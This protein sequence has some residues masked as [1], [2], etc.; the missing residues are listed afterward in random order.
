MNLFKKIFAAPAALPFFIALSFGA[1]ASNEAEL[2]D[3]LNSNSAGTVTI[4]S[5]ILISSS[6]P[7]S[8]DKHFEILLNS[9]SQTYISGASL[10]E[11]FKFESSTV[12]FI[13]S[14]TPKLVL[15]DFVSLSSGAALNAFNSVITVSNIQFSTNSAFNGGAVYV[16][17]SSINIT[18]SS[19][20]FNA[21]SNAGGAFYALGSKADISGSVFNFNV[22]SG[23]GGAVY[24]ENGI[25]N[26]TGLEFSSNTAAEGSAVYLAS[27]SASITGSDIKYGKSADGALYVSSSN[28]VLTDANFAFNASSNSSGAVFVKNSNVNINKSNITG[29]TAVAAAGGFYIENS[30]A[31]MTEVH[32][33]SNVSSGLAGALYITD[34]NVTARDIF[35]SSNIA[36]SS[37]GAG[38]VYSS[39][40]FLKNMQ[41][42]NNNA[43]LSGGGFYILNSTADFQNAVFDSNQALSGGSL[44][45]ENSSVKIEGGSFNNN[46]SSSEG[47]AIYVKSS[48]LTLSG[49]LT[50]ASNYSGTFQNDLYLDD[51]SKLIFET[52][53]GKNIILNGGM[54]SSPSAQGIEITKT[55]Q[56]NLILGGTNSVDAS[57]VS[58]GGLVILQDDS[59]LRVSS[60]EIASGSGLVLNRNSIASFSDISVN[61]GAFL[62]T[63]NIGSFNAGSVNMFGTL[64]IGI[65]VLS[66]V[67]DIINAQNVNLDSS[68]SLLE[69]VGNLSAS[70]NTY[71]IIRST[72][73]INGT[74][75]ETSGNF[76]ARIN[77]NI[78]QSANE[79]L[80]NLIIKSYADIAGL[81]KGNAK[82]V[83]ELISSIYDLEYAKNDDLW[84]NVISPMDAMDIDGLRKTAGM[85]SGAFYADLLAVSALDPDKNNFFERIAVRNDDN[86]WVHV[87][88]NIA[89]IKKD[90][91]GGGDIKDTN[92]GAKAGWDLYNNYVNEIVGVTLG[93]NYH[94]I[95]QAE[96]KAKAH[97]F[98]AGFYGGILGAHFELKGILTFGLFQYA[99]ERNITTLN[100]IAQGNFISYNSKA[101]L[102]A[103]ALIH[104]GQ[105]VVLK[106]F[107]SADGAFIQ[108][109]SFSESALGAQLYI[110]SQNYIRSSAGGGIG[111]KGEHGKFSWYINAAADYLITGNENKIKTRFDLSR[112]TDIEVSG[113]KQGDL[114]SEAS[115]GFEVFVGGASVIY[116]NAGYA[117]C[118]NYE[119]VSANLGVRYRFDFGFDF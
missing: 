92:F 35:F 2:R 67:S 54:I 79:V 70:S 40:I 27:S 104:L 77:W 39:Q 65:D 19:F 32:F 17:S 98:N 103:A 46:R 56:G 61:P 60:L 106:P 13:S 4:S 74:F 45:I 113:V 71:L 47:G 33:K 73:S 22:S 116:L 31:V 58:S 90:E 87:S 64:K 85:L 114:V 10:Y 100:Q 72:N 21:S 15:K 8:S 97:E 118:E 76:G 34:S 41:A 62:E 23:S 9:S 42:S 115:L 82:E 109:E 43:S 55:G 1:Q 112:Q 25:I 119:N 50:F 75:K 7:S 29:N 91:S 36:L 108:N 52:P 101:A 14:Q 20:L 80:L 30:S 102:Q 3:F 111:L 53:D 99:T 51:N 63:K 84:N 110:E 57:F 12:S 37:G 95:I 5:S 28:L 81:F 69:F 89:L 24:V 105:E 78:S 83:I 16:D 68:S 18:S 93:Y 66:G 88:G 59:S 11:G 49:D 94:D 86:S 96:D 107:I 44:Y 48:K 117:F 6:L 26:F 38:Y